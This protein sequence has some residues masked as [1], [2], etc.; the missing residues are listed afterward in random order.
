MFYYIRSRINK[1]VIAG[2]VLILVFLLASCASFPAA[3]VNAKLSS[4]DQIIIWSRENIVI[5]DSVDTPTF[6]PEYGMAAK[7]VGAIFANAYP[8]AEVITIVSDEYSDVAARLSG[9]SV[10]VEISGSGLEFGI[11]DPKL[12]VNTSLWLWDGVVATGQV[13]AVYPET[14]IALQFS[15]DYAVHKANPLYVLDEYKETLVQ[16]AQGLITASRQPQP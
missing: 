5:E 4:S 14:G 10:I 3:E 12:V 13:I 1:N 7:E 15:E 9:Q 16:L 2:G 6:P 8:D 11:M